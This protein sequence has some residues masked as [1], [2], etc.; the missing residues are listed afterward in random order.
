MAIEKSVNY[1]SKNTFETLNKLT[2]K[3]QKCMVCF[4]WFRIFKPVL[5]KKL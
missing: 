4:S 1:T 5:F 2:P 3:N